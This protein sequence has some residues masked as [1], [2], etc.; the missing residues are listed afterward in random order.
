MLHRS[1]RTQDHLCISAR[2]LY[3]LHQ[4]RTSLTKKEKNYKMLHMGNTCEMF[5]AAY[6][7]HK[8]ECPKCLPH[9]QF[10]YKAEKHFVRRRPFNAGTA[11]SVQNEQR[12]MYEEMQTDSPGPKNVKPSLGIWVAFM[13]NLFVGTTLKE[14][15]LVL[16]CPAP[17]YLGLQH[18]GSKVG[19]M[20]VKV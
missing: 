12:K 19:P 20:M 3:A 14:I 11:V 15:F 10:G 8:L 5:S 6:Q 18:N 17:F 13:Y 9:L 16:N 2:E 7:E 1:E 4:R